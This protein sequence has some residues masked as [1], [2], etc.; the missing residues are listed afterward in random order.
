MW[1]PSRS[2]WAV[3]W[4]G[5]ALAVLLWM[6]SKEFVSFHLFI[7]IGVGLAVWMLEGR[8]KPKA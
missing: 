1:Y 7:L 6:D 5:F 3:I 8:R 2:E 4:I